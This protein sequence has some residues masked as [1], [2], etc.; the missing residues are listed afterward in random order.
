MAKGKPKEFVCTGCGAM[1]QAMAKRDG[2][3]YCSHDC[4][5]DNRYG[6]ERPRG[7]KWKPK[8]VSLIEIVV[9][10]DC[11]TLIVRRNSKHIRCKTCAYL[12]QIARSNQ[13][14]H[15]KRIPNRKAG[16]KITRKQLHIR[17][18]GRCYICKR[19]TVL[20]NKSKKRNK[21]LATIDHV[22]PVSKGGTH[23]WTNV[24]NC[25]W[26][27]NIRKGAKELDNYQEIIMMAYE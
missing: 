15:E 20:V 25:C 10:L 19:M 2:K 12:K 16:D 27:C 21:R 9:C 1:F 4:Y 3:P 6:L 13:R 26:Q 22:I 11:E 8:I 7:S 18:G 5:L 24:R 14:E 23:T 17:D